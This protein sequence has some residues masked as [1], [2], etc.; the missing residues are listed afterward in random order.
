M[1]KFLGILVIAGTLVAC[2]NSADSS[3]NS[4]DSIDSAANAQK[5]AVDSNAN[6]L[7]NQIDSSADAKKD[8]L[9]AKDSAT[10]Q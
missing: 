5:E 8:S 7:Q 1:K 2:N 9:S 6:N 10:R 4:K 3:E